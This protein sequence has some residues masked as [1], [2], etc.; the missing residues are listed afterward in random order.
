MTVL[1]L[2][3]KET[4][5]KFVSKNW[6]ILE[7][8][9]PQKLPCHLA[10]GRDSGSAAVSGWQLW[11]RTSISMNVQEKEQVTNSFQHEKKKW[12]HICRRV[13][14]SHGFVR[15]SLLWRHHDQGNSYKGQ[16]FNGAGL[17]ILWFSS[18]SSRQEAWQHPGI[19]VAGGA[20]NSTSC[21]EDKRD[22][23]QHP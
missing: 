7:K 10:W 17:H 16:H 20:K 13:F 14:F 12:P 5:P 15:N 18:L 6:A 23:T 19:P 21:T 4:R 3:V 8:S 2:A 11:R 1:K 22:K 9:R